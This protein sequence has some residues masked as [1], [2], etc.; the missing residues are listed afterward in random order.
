MNMNE[1][2]WLIITLTIVI[3]G[4]LLIALVHMDN[5]YNNVTLRNDYLNNIINYFND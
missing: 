4:I 5:Q 1:K 2:D 3:L